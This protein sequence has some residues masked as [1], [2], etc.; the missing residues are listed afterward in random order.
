[1]CM[2]NDESVTAHLDGYFGELAH[3]ARLAELDA[4]VLDD[5]TTHRLRTSLDDDQRTLLA[6]L[7][8]P[9]QEDSPSTLT[10]PRDRGRL[11]GL[12]LGIALAVLIAL[13]ARPWSPDEARDGDLIAK[14][15]LEFALRIVVARRGKPVRVQTGERVSN[16]ERFGLFVDAP[17]PGYAAVWFVESAA[18]PTLLFPQS[19]DGKLAAGAEQALPDGGTFTQTD[20][21][22]EWAV[23][24]FAPD[25]ID[26]VALKT[27]LE[28]ARPGADCALSID[29][30][31]G[32][33][34]AT[35]AL[36]RKAAD[37]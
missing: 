31:A 19:G 25:P 7:G 28:T 3:L 32:H 8:T 15:D 6:P 26:R 11:V 34:V 33:H 17:A 29:A 20:Q 1:M 14:G 21:A 2:A 22:C 24:V 12:G 36:R 27:A 18:P 13:L 37:Q 35:V 30:P 16:G 10:P 4:G 5:A 9:P 23:G